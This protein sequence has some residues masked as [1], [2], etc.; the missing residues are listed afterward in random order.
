MHTI[1]GTGNIAGGVGR[2]D[3]GLFGPEQVDQK[4]EFGN[5]SRARFDRPTL[6]PVRSPWMDAT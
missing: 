3:N 2:R 6:K 4:G 5:I 1:R